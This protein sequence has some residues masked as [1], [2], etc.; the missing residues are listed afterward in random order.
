MPSV[1]LFVGRDGGGF[2][3][4][5]D[6]YKDTTTILLERHKNKK[7]HFNYSKTT[8][9]TKIR[10]SVALDDETTIEGQQLLR[11]AAG[12]KVCWCRCSGGGGGGGGGIGVGWQ[13]VKWGSLCN[14]INSNA[15]QT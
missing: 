6:N 1:T 12:T 10:S 5:T 2:E 15:V 11:S 7:I 14:C 8:T 3:S 13:L 9:T 4:K